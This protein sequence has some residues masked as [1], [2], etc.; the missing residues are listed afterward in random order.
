MS[1]SRLRREFKNALRD[2]GLINRADLR[3]AQQFSE[4]ILSILQRHTRYNALN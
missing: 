3:H 2:P 4:E 1:L